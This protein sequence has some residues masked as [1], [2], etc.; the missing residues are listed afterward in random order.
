MNV[1]AGLT[2]ASHFQFQHNNGLIRINI[3]IF[4]AQIYNHE[5]ICVPIYSPTVR[6]GLSLYWWQRLNDSSM[7]L[8]KY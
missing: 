3:A 7:I 6:A 5:D 2:Q 4:E 8:V 1:Q